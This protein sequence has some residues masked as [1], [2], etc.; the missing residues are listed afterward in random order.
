M[1]FELFILI[2]IF[3]VFILGVLLF[4]LKN[5]E[6]KDILDKSLKT[7]LLLVTVPLKTFEEAEK[8]KKQEKKE[9]ISIMEHFY[10]ILTSLKKTSLFD[11]AP[12]ISFEIAKIKESVLFYVSVPKKFEEFIEKQI[13]SIQP[14]AQ[15]KKVKDFNIFAPKEIVSGAYL[16]LK[17][18]FF[19]PITTYRNLEEDP[20]NSI[21][22]ALTDLK[23]KE[24]AVIQ[25]V[26]KN[27]SKSWQGKGGEIINK[28]SEGKSFSSALSS[29]NF[30][31]S[32]FN[33]FFDIV[34]DII[35]FS[36][37]KEDVKKPTESKGAVDEELIKALRAKTNKDSFEANIR[38]ICSTEQGERS[39]DILSQIGNAFAQFSTPKLNEFK[40]VKIKNNR[41]LKKLIYNYSFRIFNPQEKMILGVEELASIFHFSTPFLKTHIVRVL[42]AKKAPP[43]LDLPKQGIL[44][45]HNQ[46]REKITEVRMLEDDRRRHFYVIG[47]TGTGK[48]V[49]LSNLI[50]QDIE[51]GRGVCVM[52]PH[53]DLIEEILG[54]IPNKRIEDLVLFDPTNLKQ[55]I[56]LNMLE[57]DSQY[58][59]QKTFIVN[60]LINIFDKLY[61]LKTTGGPMFEQYTRNSLLLLM[62]DPGEQFTLMEV[63]RV[64]ADK[65]FRDRL[66][67]KCKN[68][69]VKNFWEKE[70]EK[71]GGEA[72]LVNM[73]PYIT[74]KFDVFISNDYVRPIIGQE[75]TAINFRKIMDEGK[76]L[77]VNLSKGRL[78]EIN[79]SL[80]GLIIT[81]KLTMAAF[82]RID[83]PAEKRK[84]FYFY[85]DEFQNFCTGS[86]STILSEARKY[87]LC[88]IMAHQFIKQL[89]DEIKDAVFGNVGT[90]SSFRTG[91]EDAEFLVKQFEPVF[92]SQD[93]IH[94][95][96]FNLYIKLIVSGKVSKPFNLKSIPPV[97]SDITRAKK[98]KQYSSLKYSRDIAL[99]NEEI[100]ERLTAI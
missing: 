5:R 63:P 92:S 90:I 23:P 73:V 55:P 3:V 41:K 76:I 51:Q 97:P 7:T 22:S 48:S 98:I 29:S 17:K 24:E 13:Y 60:E 70:A 25:I 34:S 45:G 21:T 35:F 71:A 28:M 50:L 82:S 67:F 66:L 80:L 58:P 59:E 16:K 39:E 42:E 56:G 43:P 88:L 74:S 77:L 62:D 53:G 52:E 9:W 4:F 86:I 8:E 93:L 46:Y 87:K 84:D 1:F 94:L 30:F 6:E 10:S 54:K 91:A 57:Y 38:I 68:I 81:V 44:L 15:I 64:L 37:K 65:S 79:S 40:I 100:R 33:N 32:F 99:V 20:L 69:M 36:S 85:M 89:P 11:T 61:D 75:K 18:P 2:F 95:E 72:A 14:D 78:G 47:Q 27:I 83:I 19:L 12:W 26:L 49:F 96:N 31:K